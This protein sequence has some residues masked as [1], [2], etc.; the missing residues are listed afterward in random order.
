[1]DAGLSQLT[2]TIRW[3]Q[4]WDIPHFPTSTSCVQITPESFSAY[5]EID[6]L[7]AGRSMGNLILL[8]DGRVL[9]LNGAG[10]G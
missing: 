10:L 4:K 2:V 9:C 8:P 5:E 7:P 3:T 6:P 1:M